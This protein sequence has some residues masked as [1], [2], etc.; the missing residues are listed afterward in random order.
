MSAALGIP[1]D[2]LMGRA[3]LTKCTRCGFDVV[4]DGREGGS[5]PRAYC[6]AKMVERDLRDRGYIPLPGSY[7]KL[8]KMCRVQMVKRTYVPEGARVIQG[9]QYLKLYGP[10]WFLYLAD[11]ADLTNM[12]IR[13]PAVRDFITM[14]RRVNA[15]FVEQKLIVGELLLLTKTDW[16]AAA[17]G[18]LR[19]YGVEN[20][21]L[22]A[23]RERQLRI[24]RAGVAIDK[25]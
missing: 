20:V 5:H 24:M 9:Q 7:V 4:N 1:Q 10:V 3:V 23:V 22:A 21:D 12:S 25:L 14:V 19:V 2:I 15:S 8:A 13:R 17:H 16:H 11:R 18:F 6:N